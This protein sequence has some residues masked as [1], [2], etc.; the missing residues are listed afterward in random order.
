MAIQVN[1]TQVIGNSR[2]LTN[3]TSVDATSAAAITAAGVGSSGPPLIKYEIIQYTG[4]FTPSYTGDAT[5]YLFGGGGGGGGVADPYSATTKR[6][7]GGGGPGSLRKTLS[8]TTSQTYTVAIGGF[9]SGGLAASSYP[10]SGG[11]GGNSTVSGGSLGGTTLIANGGAGGQANWQ[12]GGITAAAGGTASGGDANYTGFAGGIDPGVNNP[13]GD[14][15]LPE[16]DAFPLNDMNFGGGAGKL[17]NAS[18]TFGNAN[19]GWFGGLI[20]VYH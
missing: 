13:G 11:A 14:P 6:A 12:N 15:G 20:V 2:E 1:G 17:V 16:R 19:N 3:I 18:G 4:S 5:F 8:V 9:G 7:G 10:R